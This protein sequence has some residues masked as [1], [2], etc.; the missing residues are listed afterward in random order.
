MCTCSQFVRKN[1]WKLKIAM[2][3]LP[4]P[5]AANHILC[6]LKIQLWS[7]SLSLAHSFFLFQSSFSSMNKTS[8]T[9]PPQNSNMRAPTPSHTHIYVKWHLL[10]RWMKRWIRC[11][12]ISEAR[13]NHVSSPPQYKRGKTITPKMSN[14]AS[15]K[16]RLWHEPARLLGKTQR[17]KTLGC[18]KLILILLMNINTTLQVLKTKNVWS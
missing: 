16:N 17:K 5:R 13:T 3:L 8:Y 11:I 18:F 2:S 9:K 10:A 14:G 4:K 12:H 15:F 7:L 1:V 6:T